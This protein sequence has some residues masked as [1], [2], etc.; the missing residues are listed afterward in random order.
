MQS[1][2]TAGPISLT[3]A[4]AFDWSPCGNCETLLSLNPGRGLRV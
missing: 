2:D 3:G 4:S 1:T